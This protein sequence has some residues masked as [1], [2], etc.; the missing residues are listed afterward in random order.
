MLQNEQFQYSPWLMPNWRGHV[1]D[2][3]SDDLHEN[4]RCK[5]C[6]YPGAC[7]FL[8]ISYS[9]EGLCVINN[10]AKLR[11]FVTVWML[12]YDDIHYWP[13]L[14]WKW[15]N[16]DVRFE[17]GQQYQISALSQTAPEQSRENVGHPF[18]PHTKT[19][20]RGTPSRPARVKHSFTVSNMLAPQ[21]CSAPDGA[22]TK[23]ERVHSIK[24]S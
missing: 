9:W 15:K 21:I 20:R 16:H 23:N 4:P 8:T 2:L 13:D 14:T 22:R 17:G 6:V 7:Y 11:H 5:N 3:T 19:S 10:V 18:M 1:T 12:T 24:E